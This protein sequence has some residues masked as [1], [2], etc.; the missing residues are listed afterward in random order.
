MTNE[1]FLTLKGGELLKLNGE[2]YSY[3]YH[4]YDNI[5]ERL[6]VFIQSVPF[7]GESMSDCTEGPGV[8]DLDSLDV[9]ETMCAALFLF[10]SQIR[11]VQFSLYQLEF[12]K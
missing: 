6:V 11:H 5:E 8:R 12:V 10:D 3:V 7:D 9:F 2:I 4:S 1:E